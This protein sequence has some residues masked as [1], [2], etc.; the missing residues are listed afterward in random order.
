MQYK[1]NYEEVIERQTAFWERKSGDRALARIY[2][3][4]DAFEQWLAESRDLIPLQSKTLPPQ[5]LVLKTWDLKLRIL[6][7]IQDDSLPVMIPSEFDEGLFGGVFDAETVFGYDPES[8]WFSSMARPFL[9]A[10]DDLSRLSLKEDNLW[11]RELRKRLAWYREQAGDRFGISPV[12]TIDAL[13]F[14]VLARGASNAMLDTYDSPAELRKLFD[15]ALEL[16]V[17]VSRLQ[18]EIIGFFQG[19]TFDG[20]ASFGCWFPGDEINISVDAFGQ[21]RREVYLE[22]GFE[23]T[24]KLIDAF[25]SAFLHIHGD[26]HHLLPEVCRLRGLKGIWIV[27]E[28]PH[29]FPRLAEIKKITGDM[30]LV[31]ECVLGE[32]LQAMKERTLPGGV[33]YIVRGHQE[34]RSALMS[35]AVETIEEANE[36]MREVRNYRAPE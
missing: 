3:R 20:Y 8:G 30:P 5:D 33:F 12:I 17:Q 4:N 27:D 16:N 25:G 28:A 31:T 19:G 21:C 1:K 36:I 24:Q 26:A 34:G 23:Y 22:L 7:E 10:Y 29:P 13:N 11:V 15:F 35:P 6:Q 18:K 9:L 32:L 2:V 14:A